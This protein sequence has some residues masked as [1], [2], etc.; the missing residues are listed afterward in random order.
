MIVG[1]SCHCSALSI[2]RRSYCYA[3]V[4]GLI[5]S[6]ALKRGYLSKMRTPFGSGIL[7]HERDRA[8]E[9]GLLPAVKVGRARGI[10]SADRL[11]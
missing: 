3:N 10:K 6:R 5:V 9:W 7:N 2:L 8:F 4:W 1:L 11:H